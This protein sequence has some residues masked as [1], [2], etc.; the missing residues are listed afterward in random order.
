MSQC[1]QCLDDIKHPMGQVIDDSGLCTGCLTHKEK[2][3]IDWNEK[4]IS[5]EEK[6]CE[7][8]KKNNGKYDC[9]IPLNADAEDYYVVEQ[10]LKLNLKPLLVYVNNYFGTDLSWHN[11][12]NLETYFDLDLI[13][14]NPNIVYYKEAVRASLRKFNSIYW[15]YQAIKTTY[16][17]R[18]ALDMKI[19]LIVWG[20]LQATEQTGKF[21]HHDMVEMS[22]WGRVQHDLF[23]VDEE[24]FFGTGVQ[25]SERNQYHYVYPPIKQ[26]KR[27]TGIYLSN[28]MRWDPWTQNQSIIKYGFQPENSVYTFDQYERAGSSVFYTIHDILRFE[29]HGYRKVRDQLSR[30]IRHKRITRLN[31]NFLYKNLLIKKVDIKPFFK[32]L[33]S[34]ETGVKLFT[35]ERCKNTQH[36]LGKSDDSFNS[37][38]LFEESFFSAG[39]DIQDNFLIYHKGV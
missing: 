5:L 10:V 8:I 31:A 28:Y 14:F 27:V 34:T 13:T 16:P 29:K 20:G 23:C 26:A 4:W 2:D 6:C 30:E 3:C 9:I 19:P 38:T 15:P 17:V 25:I 18:L 12:H 39:A 37:E 7:I 24:S 36:L 1:I 32:W 22:G 33:G 35:R 21:S 11:L